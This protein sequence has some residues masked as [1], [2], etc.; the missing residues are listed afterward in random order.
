M[1]KGFAVVIV[2]SIAYAASLLGM[3]FAYIFYK[4][5]MVETQTQKR[6]KQE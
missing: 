2:M 1:S 4:M 6:G 3:M 5:N